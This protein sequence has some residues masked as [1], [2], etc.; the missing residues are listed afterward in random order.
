MAQNRLA[1]ACAKFDESQ[2]QDPGIGTLY[3]YADCEDRL[4]KTATAWAAFREVA[5]EARALGQTARAL[6]AD[7]LRRLA[8]I[9]ARLPRL[10][11]DPGADRPGPPG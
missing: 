4:G 10:L 7:D 9:K 6:A 2:H 1:E 8:T 5:A 3:H 11:I